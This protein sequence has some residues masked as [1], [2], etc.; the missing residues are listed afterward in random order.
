MYIFVYNNK[1][2]LTTFLLT[3][4]PPMSLS[5]QQGC[6]GTMGSQILPQTQQGIMGPYPSVSSY[7]VCGEL[8]FMRIISFVDDISV[9]YYINLNLVNT[10]SLFALIRDRNNSNLI[11]PQCWCQD[12]VDRHSVWYPLLEFKYTATLH[13]HHSICWGSPTRQVAAKMAVT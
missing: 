5:N 7:Q 8:Q 2:P 9:M 11:H 3:G 6:P 12:T 4:Y 1:I 10:C 13:L